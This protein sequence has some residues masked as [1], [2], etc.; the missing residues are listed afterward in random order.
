MHLI[1]VLAVL[2]VFWVSKTAVIIKLN[3]TTGVEQNFKYTFKRFKQ[4][5][6]NKNRYK[7]A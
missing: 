6:L 5:I 1:N 3:W 4:F 2:V 7:T